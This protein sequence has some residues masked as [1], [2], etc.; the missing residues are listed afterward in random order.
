MSGST[1]RAPGCSPA[2]P[3]WG[4]TSR[5]RT[6]ARRAAS[7]SPICSCA[8]GRWPAIDVPPERAPSMIDEYP[9]LAV[10]AACAR[11]RTIMRGLAEL[12]VKE[13][14]RLAGIAEGLARCGVDVA[15]RRRRS[16]RRG[17]RRAA[18]GRRADRD[19]ARPPHRDGVSGAR[20]G[21]ARARADRRC[22]PDRDQLSRF[23][24]ADAAARRCPLPER[25]RSKGGSTHTR[26]GVCGG[27]GAC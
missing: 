19:T 9:I 15:G 3:R 5:S 4:P 17:Q 22:P 26:G 14:D 25:Q 27:R 20:P 16:D 12:R 7:R 21:R 8:P 10:A 1:R 13:S 2:S 24:A 11:G 6:G 23:R 18:A